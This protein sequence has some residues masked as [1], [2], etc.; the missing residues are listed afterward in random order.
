MSK[1]NK[2]IFSKDLDKELFLSKYHEFNKDAIKTANY[3]GVSRPTINFLVKKYKI[4]GRRN[5][6][7]LYVE[8]KKDYVIKRY[9]EKVGVNTIS[10]EVGI[11]LSILRFY[12]KRWG[13]KLEYPKVREIKNALEADKEKIHDL[14]Y[15]KFF[16]FEEI[17]EPYKIGITR[18]SRQFKKWGW[19]PRNVRYTESSLERKFKNILEY[20]QIKYSQHFKVENR[21]YDF[22]LGDYNLLIETNGDYWHGNPKKYSYDKLDSDQ[23]KG[24]D[25][26]KVK[27]NIGIE[28]GYKIL[29]IWESEVNEKKEFLINFFEKIK[30]NQLPEQDSVYDFLTDKAFKGV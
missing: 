14:Y 5:D 15:D 2:I 13:I 24:I 27:R 1:I 20:L 30:N 8:S 7:R 12:M 18:L 26:D 22:Y 11:T 21:V 9:G 19:K 3:F 28:N 6:F 17:C 23:R 16:S 4:S 10:K 29:F 25:R